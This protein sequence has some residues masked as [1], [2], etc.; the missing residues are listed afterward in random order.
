VRYVAIGFVV[1][2]MFGTAAS[3][4]GHG[5]IGAGAVAM[6]AARN[7][8]FA[9]EYRCVNGRTVKIPVLEAYGWDGQRRNMGYEWVSF[10]EKWERPGMQ[11]GV[12]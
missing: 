9:N 2:L 6:N 3:A 4:A 11:L 7:V 12:Q 10:C 5:A 8:H 1:G